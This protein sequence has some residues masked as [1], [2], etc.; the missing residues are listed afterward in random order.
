[1]CE[2]K[3]RKQQNQTEKHRTAVQRAVIRR[4]ILKLQNEKMK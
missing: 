2:P 1:M 3:L 4:P